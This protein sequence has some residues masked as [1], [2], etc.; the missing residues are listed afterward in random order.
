MKSIHTLAL[1]VVLAAT[2]WVAFADDAH[3]PESSA[4]KIAPVKATEAVNAD[5]SGD[6][7]AKMDAQ[8]QLMRQMHEKMMAAKTPEERKALMGEQM[9]TMRDG[10]AMMNGMPMMNGMM[11]KGAKGKA[12]SPKSMQKQM[13]MMT[14]MMQ[15]MMDRM[16]VAAPP[17][18]K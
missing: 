4:P 11:D 8:M 14:M 16:E 9:K 15:M 13:D 5:K 6:Q 2:P 1:A 12:M 18:S 7:L 10:M 17:P 3:H